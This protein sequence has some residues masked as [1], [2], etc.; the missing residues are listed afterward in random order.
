MSE[1]VNQ[2]MK[3]SAFGMDSLA[4]MQLSNKLDAQFGIKVSPMQI[5]SGITL[6]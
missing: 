6:R 5:L 4:S 3:L 1:A 2:D